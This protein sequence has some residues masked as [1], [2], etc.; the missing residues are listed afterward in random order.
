MD[1]S[2]SS[3]ISGGSEGGAAGPQRILAIRAVPPRALA[4]RAALLGGFLALLST[5][6]L[7]LH[8]DG[9]AGALTGLGF[10]LAGLSLAGAT[11]ATGARDL[12]PRRARELRYWALLGAMGFVI[13]GLG[14][15]AELFEWPILL[16]EMLAILAV[17]AWW[18]VM[19][20]HLVR[21]GGPRAAGVRGPGRAFGYF[22][23][24]CA[25]A[26]LLALAAQ[27]LWQPA[28]GT[29]PARLAYVLWGPWGLVLAA[30]L[31]RDAELP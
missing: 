19:G 13:S 11:M 22:T 29:V 3:S 10:A 8:V 14:L 20:G 31:G 9:P 6:L 1:G 27:V 28:A 23:I 17:G 16:S 24:L 5:V 4:A 18:L 7:P 15:I 2:D 25:A 12:L 21:S 26:A 30:R